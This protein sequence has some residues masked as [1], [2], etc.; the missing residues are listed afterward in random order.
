MAD[1]YIAPT[2]E[3]LAKAA[4]WEEPTDKQIIG[5]REV[6]KQIKGA[7]RQISV[8]QSV[9]NRGHINREQLI[10]FQ[11]IEKLYEVGE[12]SLFAQPRRR[13]PVDESNPFCIH[14]ARDSA[15]KTI[16]QA[17]SAIGFNGGRVI[18]HCMM[19]AATMESVGQMLLGHQHLSRR[20][21]IERGKKAIQDATYELAHFFGL[22]QKPPNA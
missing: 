19:P 13:A 5:G 12:L 22:L 7:H 3:R 16:G 6:T 1:T 10:A 8:V 11:K 15:R 4:H 21:V 9:Y 18:S 17:F 2:P 20:L 14:E